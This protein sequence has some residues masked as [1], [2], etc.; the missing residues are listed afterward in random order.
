MNSKY[1]ILFFVLIHFSVFSQKAEIIPYVSYLEGRKFP[2]AKDY[3]LEKFKS[4]DIVILSEREHRDITQYEFIIEV[5]KDENFKGNIYTEVGCNNN[6]KVINQFLLNDKLSENEVENELLNIYRDLDYEIVWEKYNFYFLLSSVFEI[7]KTRNTKDKILLFPLDVSFDWNEISCHSHYNFFYESIENGLIDRN[8]IMG[9]NFIKFYEFAQ[10]RNSDRNKALVIL[11]TY[12]GYSNIPEF[13][14]LPTQPEINSAAE[15]I[16]KTYPSTTFNIYINYFKQAADG[17]LTNNGLFDA[18]LEISKKANLGF[19]LK[20]T[21]FGNATFDLYNFGDDY[22]KNI[23]FDYIFNGMIYYKSIKEMRFVVGIPNIYP[24]E[25]ENQFYER[26]SIIEGTPIDET[27]K[28]NEDFLNEVN[29]KKTF[30]LED[31]IIKKIEEQ[32]N[33]W[34]N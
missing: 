22:D 17:T 10:R 25:F 26:L 1:I 6:Y 8:V 2:T 28:N 5:L 32:I 27:I 9:K 3:I 4:N 29:T 30:Y 20:N 31:S 16:F 18:A 13:L 33:L 7:N 19:D 15:Y 21:P 14:P 11:N 24:K 34:K 12:H 23:K